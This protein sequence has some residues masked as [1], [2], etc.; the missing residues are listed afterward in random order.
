MTPLDLIDDLADELTEMFMEHRFKC[1]KDEYVPINIYKQDLPK[2]ELDYAEDEMPVPYIIV[3][4]MRGHDTGERDS[5]YTVSVCLIVGIWDGDND[6]QGYR[7]LQSIFQKIYHRFSTNP[8]LKNR[9]AYAGE[10]NWVAQ[11]DNYYPNFIGAC[12]LDF[13]IAAVRKEIPYS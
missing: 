5:F 2:L 13:H 9:A 8:I 7:D 1:R 11:E 10:W 4:L 12:N 3:R 6:S